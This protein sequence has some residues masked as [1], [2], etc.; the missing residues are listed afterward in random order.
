MCFNTQ[1]F[2]GHTC[3]TSQHKCSLMRYLKLAFS[4]SI[5]T[6]FACKQQ[7]NAPNTEG[8]PVIA[9]MPQAFARQFPQAQD[10]FWDTLD[11]GFVA[12]FFN[13]K[14][15]SKAYYDAVGNF[16]YST[17]FVELESLPTKARQWLNA[18]YKDATTAVVMLVEKNKNR[19]YQVELET[20]TDYVNLEFDADGKL[21]KEQKQALS[22]DEIQRQEEEGVEKK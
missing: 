17:I 2:F 21:L 9:A 15:D 19:T 8:S 13:G 12:S 11:N 16:Q 10:V 20:N 14:Y 3:L 22:T 6:F 4:L 7:N 1:S 5:L 18:H